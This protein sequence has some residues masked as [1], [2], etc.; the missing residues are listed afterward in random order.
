MTGAAAA[1]SS[2]GISG[3]LEVAKVGWGSSGDAGASSKVSCVFSG[4]GS[5]ILAGVVAGLIN[6]FGRGAV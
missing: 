2:A 3:G 4:G 6:G 1:S 5:D